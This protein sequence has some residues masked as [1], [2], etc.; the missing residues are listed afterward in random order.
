MDR[1]NSRTI[2]AKKPVLAIDDNSNN[3]Q[4]PIPKMLGTKLVKLSTRYGLVAIGALALLSIG[5]SVRDLRL[6]FDPVG[7]YLLGVMPNI[8]AA[9]AISFV[10]LS[11]WVAQTRIV[12]FA[13]VRPWFFAFATI[14][15][16]GL[17][18]WELAQKTSEGL[19]YDANDLLATLVGVGI[20]ILLFYMTTPRNN[21]AG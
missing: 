9:I 5:H 7:E 20:A 14:S 21:G 6:K 18:G 17:V 1:I 13:S 15:G 12:N 10:L 16:L 8:V 4:L 3:V 19:V 2:A 11:I